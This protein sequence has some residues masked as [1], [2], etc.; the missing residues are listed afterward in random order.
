MSAA[1]TTKWSSIRAPKRFY[2]VL[3]SGLFGEPP[4]RC[5][6]RAAD[7][8]PPWER[9]LA[10]RPR[11]SGCGPAPPKQSAELLST[12]AQKNEPIKDVPHIRVIGKK[13]KH[14]MALALMKA[15]GLGHRPY[16]VK[17]DA[18]AALLESRR[19]QSRPG[20]AQR[21]P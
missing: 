8:R 4:T 12:S 9:A 11:A 14:P 17:A 19:R 6:S 20:G 15:A 16:G 13:V 7:E 5:R 2:S 18:Q 21:G 1:F 3:S 10:T